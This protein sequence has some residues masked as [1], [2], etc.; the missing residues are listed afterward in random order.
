MSGYNDEEPLI[1]VISNYDDTKKEW[2]AKP[3]KEYDLVDYLN[4][5]EE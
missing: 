1:S 4:L 5:N 2:I 3:I